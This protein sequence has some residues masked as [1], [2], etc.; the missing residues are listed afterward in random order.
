LR[1]VKEDAVKEAQS[2]IDG[3]S[4]T[5]AISQVK[6]NWYS[7]Q[8]YMTPWEI[9]AAS[10]S[11]ASLLTS[12]AI[13]IGYAISGGLK[14]IPSFMAG[15]AGFGGSPTVNVTMG[16]QQVGNGAEMA[17]KTLEA[18]ASGLDKAAGMA[19][20]QA[21]Y[22]R[23]EEE[24][25]READIASAELADFDGKIATAVLQK[26]GAD[27]DLK[28]H[29]QEM[30]NSVAED[31]YLHSK[32]TNQELFDWMVRE[33]SQTYFTVYKLAFDMAKRQSVATNWN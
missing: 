13:S 30:T 24:W 32:Y 20:V 8:I 26:K 29:D 9:I 2:A 27:D 5:K 14:L 18:I 11:G 17:V 23:R 12:V 25:R 15:G 16:G 31:I 19:T 3:L 4:L 10:L 6:Y 22:R 7:T 21:G 33:T 1:K 28:A